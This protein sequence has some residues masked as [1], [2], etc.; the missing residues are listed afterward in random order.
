M[1]YLKLLHIYQIHLKILRYHLIRLFLMNLMYPM[2]LRYL[3]LLVDLM[4]QK[5]LK[6]LMNHLYH[7]NLLHFLIS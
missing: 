1:M 2:N 5:F 3:D 4:S 7:L 6:Y